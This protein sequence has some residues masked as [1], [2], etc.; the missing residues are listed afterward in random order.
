M[1]LVV[2]GR[3]LQDHDSG[4]WSDLMAEIRREIPEERGFCGCDRNC[5]LADE[6]G[7]LV[8]VPLEQLALP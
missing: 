4:D 8:L 6:Q 3:V 5:Q 2:E 7:R 1:I